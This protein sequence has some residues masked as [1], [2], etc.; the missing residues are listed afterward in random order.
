MYPAAAYWFFH[1]KWGWRGKWQKLFRRYICEN[2]FFSCQI[3]KMKRN[4]SFI[5]NRTIGVLA[6]GTDYTAMRPKGHPVMPTTEMI[7]ARVDESLDGRNVDRIFLATE[8]SG[9]LKKFVSRY[10]NRLLTSQKPMAYGGGFLS[11][12]GDFGVGRVVEYV[13]SMNILSECETFI[14]GMTSGA[15]YTCLLRNKNKGKE[16]IYDLGRYC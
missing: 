12:N 5:A 2:E 13:A 1:D 14:S 9:I 4:I 11:E 7:F 10:G 15:V 16:M 8:D 6:R 3:E